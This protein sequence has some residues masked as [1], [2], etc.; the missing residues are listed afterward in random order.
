MLTDILES[1]YFEPEEDPTS[2]HLVPRFEQALFQATNKTRAPLLRCFDI[3]LLR[4]S[5]KKLAHYLADMKAKRDD[6]ERVF[7]ENLLKA[8]NKFQRNEEALLP[9]AAYLGKVLRANPA[10]TA[11]L[12]SLQKKVK[13]FETIGL[14]KKEK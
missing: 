14:F 10:F 5:L 4:S 7:L 6:E 12:V 3:A 9:S 11:P 8:Y 13:V 2:S 1:R